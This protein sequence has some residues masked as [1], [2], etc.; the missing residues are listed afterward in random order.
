MK[1]AI[2]AFARTV[3][4]GALAGAAPYMGL[5]TIPMALFTAADGNIF[6]AAYLMVVP[7]I[8]SG[9]IVLGSAIVFGLPLTAVLSRGRHESE[10]GYALLGLGL[11]AVIPAAVLLA[12]GDGLGGAL[13][14]VAI[15][16]AFAGFVTGSKWGRWREALDR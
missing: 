4:W 9:P 15:P 8:V 1:A 7:L 12:L 11:G 16:G 5:L 10:K 6:G 2:F 13:L 14:F 3:G